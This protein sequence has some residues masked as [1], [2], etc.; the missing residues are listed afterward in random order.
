MS[1]REKL[2]QRVLEGGSLKWDDLLKLMEWNGFTA[3][4]R[5]SHW[6]FSAPWY[7]KKLL[8]VIQKEV[9]CRYLSSFRLMLRAK[10]DEAIKKALTQR[11]GQAYRGGIT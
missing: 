11:S 2:E 9:P 7:P 4:V 5:G 1:V 3:K 6:T 8:V 10:R